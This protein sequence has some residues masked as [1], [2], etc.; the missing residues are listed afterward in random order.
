M[1]QV[2]YHEGFKRKFT[3]KNKEVS[4][5]IRDGKDPGN[6]VLCRPVSPVQIE[7]D[8]VADSLLTT[9]A[10]AVVG[11]TDGENKKRKWQL[12]KSHIGNML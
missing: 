10:D 7:D 9:S 5:E 1:V 6:I 4:V 11:G 2:E 8:D 3:T 12:T